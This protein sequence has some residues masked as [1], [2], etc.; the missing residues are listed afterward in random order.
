MDYVR[1]IQVIGFVRVRKPFINKQNMPQHVYKIEDDGS[2]TKLLRFNVAD[3]CPI[4]EI[5]DLFKKVN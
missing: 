4:E 2:E 3:H 5:Q 1:E